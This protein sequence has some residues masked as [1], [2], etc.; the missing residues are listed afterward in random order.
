MLL[1]DT[2][3]ALAWGPATHVQIASDVLS[4]LTVLPP[5]IAILLARHAAAYVYGTIAADMVFAKRLS[6][7]KQFCHHWSTG[8]QLRENAETA[9]AKAFALGYLSHLAADTVAHGKYVPR[10]IAVSGST[11]NFGHLYWELRADNLADPRAWASLRQSLASDHAEHHESM[12]GHLTQTFLPYEL[13]RVL[14]DRI[15]D[16]ATRKGSRRA[17]DVVTRCSKH[18]LPGPL[19][20]AYRGEC[21]DRTLDVLSRGPHS[22]VLRDDPNGTAA[23]IQSRVTRRDLRRLNRRGH[24]V[25]GFA[26][27]MVRSLDPAVAS[28]GP[29]VVV[30]VS[31]R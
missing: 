22:S 30:P 25:E 26:E 5:A 8:F 16:L 9:A 31:N 24:Q 23:L 1:L 6:R 4:R 27:E 15:N 19:L 29:A 14:F 17:M 10:Q 18:E 12:A 28:P 20:E 11:V 7:V 3:S 13:N 21:L 2:D